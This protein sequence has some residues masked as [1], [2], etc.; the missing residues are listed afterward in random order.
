MAV[1]YKKINEA[2]RLLIGLSGHVMDRS[3][4]GP[5]KIKNLQSLQPDDLE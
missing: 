2:R 3:V 5:P 1:V 4:V